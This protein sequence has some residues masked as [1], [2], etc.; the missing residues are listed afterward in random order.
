M[1]IGWQLKQINTCSRLSYLS[2]LRAFTRPP[3]WMGLR[4]N[5]GKRRELHRLMDGASCHPL[6]EGKRFCISGMVQA[7]TPDLG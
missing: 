5:R 4:R 3:Y 7:L 2:S 6:G 1:H